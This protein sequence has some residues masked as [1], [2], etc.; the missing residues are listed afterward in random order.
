MPAVLR[1]GEVADAVLGIASRGMVPETERH[2]FDGHAITV[3]RGFPVAP[4]S[5]RTPHSVIELSR[6]GGGKTPSGIDVQ[7][8]GV[9]GQRRSGE[10]RADEPAVRD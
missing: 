1:V 9:V 5:V 6:I 3:G 10:L 8:Q 4:I 2:G 7:E